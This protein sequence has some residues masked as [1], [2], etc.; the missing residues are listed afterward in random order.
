MLNKIHKEQIRE[1][2]SQEKVSESYIG[3]RFSAAIGR[4]LH[5]A[6]VDFIRNIINKYGIRNV[7]EIAPGPARLTVDIGRGNGNLKGT[8][9]DINHNMLLKAHKRLKEAGL[10]NR[11]QVIHGDAFSLPFNDKFQM[12]YTFRFIRHFH[13][14]DRVKIYHQIHEHLDEKGLLIFDAVNYDVSLP[15]R[16]KEGLEKYPVYDELYK[17]FD[18]QKEI[19][20]NGFK[21]IDYREVQNN[22]QLQSFIQNLVAP[23]SDT[24]AYLLLKMVNSIK[25]KPLEWLVLCQKI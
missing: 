15:L 14:N 5:E 17:F 10:D 3:E 4:V 8:I 19:I 11:W 23:H 1:A 13:I 24:L 9:I 21:I 22:Y 16:L 7:L 2:Y 25:R 6:Q 18:L 20:Q 12:V